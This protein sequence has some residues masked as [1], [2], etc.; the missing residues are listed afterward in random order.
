MHKPP[1]PPQS[2]DPEATGMERALPAASAPR[3]GASLPGAGTAGKRVYLET[4]GC[5]KN[6]VDSEIMAGALN[7]GGYRLTLE[8]AEAEVIVVNTCAFLGEASQESIDRILA[9]SDFKRNGA[10]EKIVCAGCLSQRYGESLLREI[11]ELDGL[12]GSAD[13]GEIPALLDD[14]YR[15]APDDS[16][17]VRVRKKPHYAHY[18][19]QERLQ[20]TPAPYVYVKVAEGCSNM[21]SFCNIPLLRGRFSSRAIPDILAEV[22]GHL[23]RGVKEINLISQDTSSFGV[24]RGDGTDLEGLLRALDGLGGQYWVRIFYAYPN[25]LG[26][27]VMEAI[28]T[29]AHIVPYLDIPF[30]HISGR[31]LRD[32][33]RRITEGQIRAKLAELRRILPQ[34]TLRTTFIAG[35]PTESE[36]DF[37]ALLSF[38]QEGWF[39][40]AGVFCYSHEDNIPSRRFGDPV[41]NAIKRN[42]RKVLLEAQQKVSAARNAGRVGLI[43]PVL[44]EGPSAESDLLLQGRAPFQGPEVDGVVYVNEGNAIAGEFHQVEITEAHAYDLVGRIVSSAA[45]AQGDGC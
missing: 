28:A 14:L 38:V 2:A 8:P 6:R 42:R 31:V 41:P 10:C 32:M 11:A 29:S 44:V 25:T 17:R 12:L 16:L 19:G 45:G 33:N 39:D 43:F 21:C 30:Q 35:F 34:A 37:A 22:A 5:A 40:H 18:E 4:L 7:R 3:G 27:G 13:F 20:S 9:L 1:A 23:E 26:S 24:E 15:G 36:A